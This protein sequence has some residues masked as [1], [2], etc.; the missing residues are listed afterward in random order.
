[1]IVL[2]FLLSFLNP[3]EKTNNYFVQ[4]IIQTEVTKEFL[5]GKFDYKKDNRFVLIDRKWSSKDIYVQKQTYKAFIKMADAAK[6]DGVNLKIV[7]GTRSFKEQKVI[8]EKKW[9]LN[10]KKHNEQTEITLNILKFS[11]MPGSSRHHWG[12]DIDIN[13]VEEEY[14]EKE[15]GKKIYEW[16]FK[17]APKYGF[18]QV[19]TNKNLTN[20]E[21]YEEEKWHWSYMAL[22]GLYLESYIK[23]INYSDITGFLGSETA[24]D[25]DII[26]KY[27][28][29]I[30]KLKN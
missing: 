30:D 11:S 28:Q 23:K 2:V 5:L 13:S 18:H 16:L 26:K 9:K 10:E 6:K 8:W 3:F 1:M 4:Q 29:G 14:F 21:G 12:T 7:S 15:E 20:R 25:I 19:Y 17:N 24:K 22:S 27:V